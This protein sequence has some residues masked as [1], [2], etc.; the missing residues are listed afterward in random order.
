MWNR[1]RAFEVAAVGFMVLLCIY[2][3]LLNISLF[4]NAEHGLDHRTLSK[5]CVISPLLERLLVVVTYHWDVT[6]LV[7]LATML[8]VIRTYETQVDVVIVTDNDKALT[9]ILDEWGYLQGGNP[10]LQI[11]QAPATTDTQ[12]Y[13][14]LWAH[15]QAVEEQLKRHPD[16]TSIIYMEDDTRLSW[17]TVTSWALD[18]EVLA[19]QNFSRCIYRTEVATETGGLNMMDWSV[20]PLYMTNKNIFDA[21]LNA[22]YARVQA[23]LK[24]AAAP[25][26]CGKHRD[27]SS[28]PCQVHDRYVQPLQPYQGMWMATRAQLALFMA[29]P[30]WIKEKALVATLARDMIMGYPERSTVMNLLINVPEGF[31][32]NCMVPFVLSDKSGEQPKPILPSV[33]RVE[34]MRNGYSSDLETPLGKTP[35]EVAMQGKATLPRERKPKKVKQ[36]RSQKKYAR[37]ESPGQSDIENVKAMRQGEKVI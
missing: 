18:T 35:V 3:L 12:K 1:R 17:P 4:R 10:R 30:F 14:L 23:R 28:W 13:A 21:T 31:A 2:V 5:R 20:T 36:S 19:P 32:S 29:H 16:Y 9:R 27:G 6:K 37:Q 15:R 34:H 33:A 24:D 26:H 8:D 22:D 11:W 7:Y 25:C